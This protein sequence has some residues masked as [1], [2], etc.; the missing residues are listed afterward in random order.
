MKCKVCNGTG[1]TSY[2]N[3]RYYT[4]EICKS[5]KGTGEVERTNEEWFDTLSTETKAR[6]THLVYMAGYRD[7]LN[8]AETIPLRNIVDWLKQP[9]TKGVRNE[10]T[11]QAKN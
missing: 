3:G 5:C 4:T 8:G 6:I 10:E 9:Y 11:V 1:R 2:F 7:G